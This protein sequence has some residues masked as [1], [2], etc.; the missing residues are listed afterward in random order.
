MKA[1]LERIK[2]FDLT[3]Y[4]IGFWSYTNLGEHAIHMTE[5]EVK[6]WA[7]AG[8]TVTQSPGFDPQDRSQ[9]AHVRRLLDWA[10]RHGM[11][12][13]VCDPRG[14]AKKGNRDEYAAGIRAAVADLGDHPA[15]F[16]FHV[17]DEPEADFKDTF[18]ECG[19]IQKEI[20]P[21]LH[22]YANLLPHFDWLLERAGAKT[23]PEYLDEYVKKS[24]ADM[25]GY[26]CY[27]HMDPGDAGWHDYYRNLKLYREAALRNG[28]P[29]WNTVLSVGH[30]KFRCPNQDELRWQFNTSLAAGANG[31][32]WF[33]YY[34]RQPHSNF[35]MSPVDEHWDKTPAYYDLRRIQL[36][37]HKRYGDLFNRIAS[38][39]V[40]FYG[41]AYGDGEKFSPS[42]IVKN[43][44]HESG[45]P[46]IVG[47][48][49]DLEGKRYAM[50]VNNSM[51]ESEKFRVTFPAGARL[52]SWD[53]HGRE[54]EG[55]PY[56]GGG[57]AAATDGQDT[58]HWPW[59]APGQEAVYRIE[60]VA[61]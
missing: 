52:Y 61:K 56:A 9:V 45:A 38:T 31:I 16:G 4:P 3:K 5:A 17:G 36:S 14:Y 34:M 53:W 6:S 23:W 2:S 40:T 39:R 15:L 47:E 10:G 59:L 51:T 32:V 41:K 50:F 7:D 8:F 25:I 46:M 48:F 22:P 57:G 54:Y 13:I 11:K 21:H 18:F 42:D 12:L 20:A 19:R 60:A 27:S 35:R 58:V 55:G 29:F 24:N 26:D 28:V 1:M 33:F 49:A 44:E 43:V 30:Y 37:F